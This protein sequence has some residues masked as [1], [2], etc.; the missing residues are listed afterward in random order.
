MVANVEVICRSGK[1]KGKHVKLHSYEVVRG[2]R[3]RGSGYRNQVRGESTDCH[4][5]LT[6]FCDEKFA[7]Q[8]E[9]DSGKKIQDWTVSNKTKRETAER[10]RRRKERKQRQKEKAK[11]KAKRERERAKKNKSK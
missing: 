8:W 1:H 5:I 2:K 4:D 6:K 10:S 7:M 3:S 9:K 11:A